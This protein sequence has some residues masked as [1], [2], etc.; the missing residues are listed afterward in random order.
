MM[1]PSK[2]PS[3]VESVGIRGKENTWMEIVVPCKLGIFK[4]KLKRNST[5][6]P[7]SAK[8]K[9]WRATINKTLGNKRKPTPHK[10]TR[11][12]GAVYFKRRQHKSIDMIVN[13]ALY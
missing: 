1:K 7:H 11:E 2:Y 5:T 6:S 8:V 12:M 10:K 4:C 3:D 13:N 9:E